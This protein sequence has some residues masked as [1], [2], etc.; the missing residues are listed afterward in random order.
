MNILHFMTCLEYQILHNYVQDNYDLIL[1]E[2][3]PINRF[4]HTHVF[5]KTIINMYLPLHI[6]IRYIN[7]IPLCTGYYNNLD[8]NYH[9]SV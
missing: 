1:H 2:S 5:D 4:F 9:C 3:E 6:L 7:T 8:N